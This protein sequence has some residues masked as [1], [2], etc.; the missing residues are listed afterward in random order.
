MTDAAPL[1]IGIVGHTN[2][3]KTSLVRTLTR[4][5]NFGEVEDRGG[6]TRRVSAATLDDGEATR[7]RLW[8]SP[9]LENAPALLEHL[10][11]SSTER[12]DGL[13]ALRRL[14]DDADIVRRFPEET[15]VLEL[16]LSCDGLLYVI[17]V[18]EPV[19]EK[20][21]DELAVLAASARPI[22]AVLNFVAAD[23]SR[24]SQWRDAL[25]RVTLHTV[26]A[27]DAR[28]RSFETEL[29][30]YRKIASQLN[31]FEPTIE[32][33]IAHRESEE[34]H[35]R[36]AARETIATLLVDA[37]AAQRAIQPT[38]PNGPDPSLEAL[39]EAI[40]AREQVCSET[41]L[42][43][44]AFADEDYEDQDWP[45]ASGYWPDDVF[46]ADS[47]KRYARQTAIYAGIGVV[48]GGAL[49]LATG[50]MGTRT[51]LLL[52]LLVGTGVGAAVAFGPP[53]WRRSYGQQPVC[54]SDETLERLTARQLHLISA[55][56]HR[57]HATTDTL[58]GAQSAL[59][60]NSER[61]ALLREARRHP[62]WSSLNA[63]FRDT[64]RRN[65][66]IGRISASLP[67]FYID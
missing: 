56:N 15:R 49:G 29:Q 59:F 17:D 21:K 6:T 2:A 19:L 25:A 53:L 43:L 12:H 39:R 26:V 37:A 7:L 31:D 52:G 62:E 54:V 42:G 27:F 61:V 47:L 10:D 38:D 24:E 40:R 16:T 58:A 44:Y 66:V 32:A 14:L 1:D 28:V 48:L 30:L 23:D 60:E 51:G 20:Y 63:A 13:A 64:A 67:D 55:L 57:G 22:I 65:E 5:R 46:N 45:L 36:A 33:W 9:G 50:L 41:L 4:N 35:C 8:D 11:E 34:A 3:G 18:R